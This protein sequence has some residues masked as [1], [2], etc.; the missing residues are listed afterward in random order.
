MIVIYVPCKD[1]IEA[2]KIADVLIIE[3]LAVCV[4]IFHNIS[5]IYRWKKNKEKSTEAV[6]F[7]KT[8]KELL[9]KVTKRV[10]ELHS[11]ESPVIFAL[12]VLFYSPKTL[13]YL[14]EELN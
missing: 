13:K 3:Q 14:N 12:P 11:Y 6:M 2:E 7:I 10:E 1:K 5:S 8:K 4:N 9:D